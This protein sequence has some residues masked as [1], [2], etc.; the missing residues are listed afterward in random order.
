MAR[1]R[2]LPPA[3]LA[4]LLALSPQPAAAETLL[5]R[6]VV[7]TAGLHV[8]DVEAQFELDGP[9]YRV[10]AH[11]RTT[12]LAGV[13]AHGDHVTSVE[14]EWRGGEPTPLRYRAEGVWRG[15]PRAVVLDWPSPG[16][17]V[18][19]RLEP[20]NQGERE[21]VPEALARNTTDALS[22]LARLVR[23]V[24]RT[25]RCDGTAAVYDGR[26][27]V[28]YTAASAGRQTLP[29]EGGFA[30]EALRCTVESRLLAGRRDD[31]DPA[32]ARRPQT[33]SVW[34]APPLPGRDPIP[35]RVELPNR[36]FGTTRAV[37]VRVERLPS[38]QEVAQ[39][40]H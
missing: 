36:W 26:R 28:D 10:R 7:R 3:F 17:P 20:P 15:G 22:A 25:G 12:G 14:G 9:R 13:F 11:V 34:L 8:M 27:R 16:Q 32:E 37:L 40:R 35:V 24:A 5:A 18:L 6:Y 38:G 19:R 31:Q 29:A 4:G 21:P 23:T 33:A 1:S 30:G 2:L 39:Q